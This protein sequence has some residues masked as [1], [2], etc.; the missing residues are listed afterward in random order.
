[1]ELLSLHDMIID[2]KHFG[3]QP[4]PATGINSPI[5]KEHCK[6]LECGNAAGVSTDYKPD[7]S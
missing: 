5:F 4:K 2:L 6:A 1:M 3:F 7:L